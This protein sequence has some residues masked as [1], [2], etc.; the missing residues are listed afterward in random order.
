[1]T[2]NNVQLTQAQINAVCA[3]YAAQNA[4]PG[5]IAYVPTST[6]PQFLYAGHFTQAIANNST[7]QF[8]SGHSE[9][10]LSIPQSL[11]ATLSN[12]GYGND[13]QLQGFHNSTLSFSNNHITLTDAKDHLSDSFTLTDGIS[14]RGTYSAAN[15]S[16][17]ETTL[18]EVIS[19]VPH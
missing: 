7:I 18:G 17:H 5:G 15:F 16:M 10:V 9:A 6:T 2:P 11:Q 8:D 12:F 19:F 4:A 1:V 3:S 14:V 13:I